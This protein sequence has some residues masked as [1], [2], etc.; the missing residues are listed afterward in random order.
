MRITAPCVAGA[1]AVRHQ[2]RRVERLRDG[3]KALRKL[4]AD[5][6]LVAHGPVE[7]ARVVPQPLDVGAP[8][9]EVELNA[10]GVR[11]LP[12]GGVDAGVIVGVI[13]PSGFGS[14]SGPAVGPERGGFRRGVIVSAI[15]WL[16]GKTNFLF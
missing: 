15:V 13:V 1:V 9:L 6:V 16:K 2:P 10:G 12:V 8:R 3:I 4:G 11:R 7:D 14:I 5:V